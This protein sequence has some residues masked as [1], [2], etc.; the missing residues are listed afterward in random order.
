LP[1][2]T[3]TESELGLDLTRHPFHHATGLVFLAAIPDGHEVVRHLLGRRSLGNTIR[4][5]ARDGVFYVRME[6]AA[7]LRHDDTVILGWRQAEAGSKPG[8]GSG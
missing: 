7:T 6:T 3:A 5:Y 2:R 8:Q 4:F 1:V